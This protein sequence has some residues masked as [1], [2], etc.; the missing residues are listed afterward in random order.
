M[1]T[2]ASEVMYDLKDFLTKIPKQ[3]ERYFVDKDKDFTRSSTWTPARLVEFNLCLIKQ[4][5]ATEINNFFE[6]TDLDTPTKQSFGK[7]RRKLKIAVFKDIFTNINKKYYALIPKT[8][9]DKYNIKSYDSTTVQ[10]PDSP[11]N[12]TTFGK[13]SNNTCEY[14]STKICAYFDTKQHLVSNLYLFNRTKSDTNCAMESIDDLANND[15][16]VYDRGF[17]GII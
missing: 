7:A 14:A 3:P 2:I 11:D 10:V 5:T 6:A 1:K 13:Y 16:G 4:S 17:G 8:N 12:R 15:I 9:P